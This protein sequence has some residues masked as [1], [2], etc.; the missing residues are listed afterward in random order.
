MVQAP[1]RGAGCPTSLLLSQLQGDW[2][3]G[4]GSPRCPQRE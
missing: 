2:G 1:E 4:V 3:T